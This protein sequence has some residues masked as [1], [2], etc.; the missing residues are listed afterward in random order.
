M[1]LS[2]K[3]KE[4]EASARELARLKG[5]SITNALLECTKKEISRQKELRKVSPKDDLWARIRQIQRE[6][7]ELPATGSTLSDDEVLGYDEY[8]IPSK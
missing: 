2:I 8:G 6:Y 5:T 3:N 1:A 4:L 7:A